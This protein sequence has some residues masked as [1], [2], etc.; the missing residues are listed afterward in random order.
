MGWMWPWWLIG[1]AVVVAIVWLAVS[2]TRRQ[3]LDTTRHETRESPED[4]L[5][6]RYARGEIDRDTYEERLADLRQ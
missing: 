2:W 4:V 1:L 3:P 6:K 5:K